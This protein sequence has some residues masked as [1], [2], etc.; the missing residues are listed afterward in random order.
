MT[1][2]TLE[3]EKSYWDQGCLRLAGVDD[4]GLGPICGPVLACA[5]LLPAY[6]C[7]IDGVR[8]SKLL[9]PAKR[10]ELALL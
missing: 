4:V 9:A 2:P 10:E 8:D 7:M 5:V 3:I 1:A 6:C